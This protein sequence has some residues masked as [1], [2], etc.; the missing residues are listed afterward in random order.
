MTPIVA[1]T[2]AEA[3]SLR[4]SATALL[5]GNSPE[6]RCVNLMCEKVGQGCACRLALS[7]ERMPKLAVLDISSNALPIVPDS[8]WGLGGSLEALNLAGM[9]WLGCEYSEDPYFSNMYRK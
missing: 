9:S 2:L 7:L 5:L 3:Y 8:L 1:R 4:A 6:L